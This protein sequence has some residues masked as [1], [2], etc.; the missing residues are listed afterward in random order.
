MNK[1]PGKKFNARI[2]YTFSRYSLET[3]TQ[4]GKP[5]KEHVDGKCLFESTI[6]KQQEVLTFFEA[7]IRKGGVLTITTGKQTLR[8]KIKALSMEQRANGVSG[9]ILTDGD[10][11]LEETDATERP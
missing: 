3:C 11:F 4:C 8:Q 10:V 7:L 2:R 9:E 1:L 6:F 5:T